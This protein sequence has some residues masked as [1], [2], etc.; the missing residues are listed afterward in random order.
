MFNIG[1]AQH[2]LLLYLNNCHIADHYKSEKLFYISCEN[3]TLIKN[4]LTDY[5]QCMHGSVLLEID[6]NL[7]WGLNKIIVLH[8]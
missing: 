4:G 7:P 2:R 5:C 8:Y 1:D 6:I 3:I